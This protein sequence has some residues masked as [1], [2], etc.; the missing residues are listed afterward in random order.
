ML[1]RLL[2]IASI[3]CLVLCVALMG[4]WVRS[5]QVKDYLHG[6]LPDSHGFVVHSVRG[7]L[8]LYEFPLDSSDRVVIPSRWPWQ[9]VGE[10]TTPALVF[11][12]PRGGRISR[13]FGFAKYLSS[14]G[15]IVFLPYWFMVLASGSLAMLFRLRWPW[16]FDLRSLFIATTFLAVVLGMTAWLDH[17]WIGK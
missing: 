9:V 7:E 13:V 4:M 17:S 10:A 14:V 6:P 5:Y 15:S 2:N 11:A 16:R 3:V 8:V 1:R 12:L